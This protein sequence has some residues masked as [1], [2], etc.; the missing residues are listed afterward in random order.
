LSWASELSISIVVCTRN[1]AEQL[2]RMLT[3]ALALNVP[4]GLQWELVVVDNGSK[5]GTAAV[6]EAHAAR[7]PLRSVFEPLAGLSHARNRGVEEARGDFICWTDDDVLLDPAWLASYWDAIRR[8][9]E[10]AVFGGRILPCLELPLVPW[11]ERHLGQWPLSHV[12]AHRDFGDAILPIDYRLHRLP[13]GA[14]F[15]VR[16]EEQRRFRYNPDLT[17][18]GEE[19]DLVYRI[20]KEGGS[21]FWVPGSVVTH[22][23]PVSRQT[24][25]YVLSYFR[26][27]GREAAHLHDVL[28]GDNIHHNPT[29]VSR[30]VTELFGL[31]VCT[32]I[33]SV[34]ARLVGRTEIGLRFWARYGYC[35][36]L[37]DHRRFRSDGVASRGT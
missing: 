5:D 36:G 27:R 15:A 12:V 19:I 35:R 34:A 1:R 2:R 16:T 20:L 26:L 29:W 24:Y 22:V 14:N 23:I 8:H 25:S 7:L 9:P 3:T 18:S 31:A 32:L 17:G 13:W 33:I 30:S 21:G 4:D 10:A 6:V 11:F 28:P 37:I